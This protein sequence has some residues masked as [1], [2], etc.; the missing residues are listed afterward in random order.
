[1]HL[2]DIFVGI[3]FCT[4]RRG[5]DKKNYRV[6]Q[7]TAMRAVATQAMA[8]WE[9]L[10]FSPEKESCV[11]W[12][13]MDGKYDDSASPSS[14]RRVPM[15]WRSVPFFLS[16][17]PCAPVGNRGLSFTLWLSAIARHMIT[18]HIIEDGPF[19]RSKHTCTPDEDDVMTD[20]VDASDAA[21]EMKWEGELRCRRCHAPGS[22]WGLICRRHR[23]ERDKTTTVLRV[24]RACMRRG[25][26]RR[27]MRG[28]AGHEWG[29]NTNDVAWVSKHKTRAQFMALLL[30]YT[31]R[32][33]VCG[34][35]KQRLIEYHSELS[36][37]GT[38]EKLH[39]N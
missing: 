32:T 10:T 15:C 35:Y 27:A 21:R 16:L 4:T 36:E 6:L 38:K 28:D 17:L 13:Y 7:R 24:R 3:F 20:G 29:P 14:P 31:M 12:K 2:H 5:R 25:V 23:E 11:T 33:T 9:K 18:S 8:L 39:Q 34:P 22:F 19:C 37:A 1:M 26:A 30:A